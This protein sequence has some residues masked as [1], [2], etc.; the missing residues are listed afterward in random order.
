M[1]DMLSTLT[2]HQCIEQVDSDSVQWIIF[3]QFD[4]IQCTTTTTRHLSQWTIP[5][6]WQPHSLF[7]LLTLSLF[8]LLLLFLLLFFHL[9]TS[10]THNNLSSCWKHSYYITS[11]LLHLLN[12]LHV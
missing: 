4:L 11:L 5:H 12:Q 1:F 9:Y 10:D 8:L 6:N 7:S 3:L 2:V